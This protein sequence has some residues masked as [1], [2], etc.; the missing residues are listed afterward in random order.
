[1]FFL[2]GGYG[3]ETYGGMNEFRGTFAT[4]EE[5]LTVATTPVLPEWVSNVE[6]EEWET[7][8]T[9]QSML[10]F[11]IATIVNGELIEQYSKY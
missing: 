11:Q 10:W 2:F 6:W 7:V 3:V 9:A 4:F 1:M 5:A 8:P